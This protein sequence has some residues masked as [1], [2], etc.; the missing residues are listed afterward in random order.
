MNK[1]LLFILSA[2]LP[3]L[4]INAQNPAPGMLQSGKELVSGVTDTLIGKHYNHKFIGTAS[5]GYYI[6]INNW[7]PGN[8]T[9]NTLTGIARDARSLGLLEKD[10]INQLANEIAK[11][12]DIQNPNRLEKGQI[13]YLTRKKTFKQEIAET[14]EPAQAIQKVAEKQPEEKAEKPMA[15]VKQTVPAATGS[16]S[17]PEAHTARNHQK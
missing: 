5:Q 10:N 11:L 16:K 9:R 3:L 7:S 12:N 2:L 4:V 14:S 1:R 17:Q 15:E 13:I 8:Q 6:V